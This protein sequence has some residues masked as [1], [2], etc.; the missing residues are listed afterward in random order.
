VEDA[1]D[2]DEVEE[3]KEADAADVVDEAIMDAGD[4]A[5]NINHHHHNSNSYPPPV[6]RVEV[7]HPHRDF[8]TI[9]S[10]KHEPTRQIQLNFLT[11][12]TCA[13]TVGTTSR[14]GI[15]AKHAH[16][17]KISRTTMTGSIA[18]MQSNTK[19]QGGK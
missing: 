14:S 12:G 18:I 10:Y 6:A 11:T 16:T 7:S 19:Q 4:M 15:I 13:A 9:N 2:M 3:D 5:T 8:G 1:E 17:N